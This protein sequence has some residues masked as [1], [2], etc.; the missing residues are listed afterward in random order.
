M[1]SIKQINRPLPP[2]QKT[3]LRPQLLPPHPSLPIELCF[4]R[5]LTPRHGISR[6]KKSSR[7]VETRFSSHHPWPGIKKQSPTLRKQQKEAALPARPCCNRFLTRN[8]N[9]GSL[10]SV[11]DSQPPSSC[12]QRSIPSSISNNPPTHHLFYLFFGDFHRITNHL[13]ITTP[14]PNTLDGFRTD[15]GRAGSH[16]TPTSRITLCRIDRD[17]PRSLMKEQ[18]LLPL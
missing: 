11:Q 16:R 5:P 10:N 9:C 7:P 14:E 6:R 15:L 4:R 18:T 12:H 13:I 1:C 2:S 8:G 3:L 17:H